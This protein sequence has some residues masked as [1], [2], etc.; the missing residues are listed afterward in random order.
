MSVHSVLAVDDGFKDRT[1]DEI[2]STGCAWISSEKNEGKGLALKRA[3]EAILNNGT[4]P[5]KDSYE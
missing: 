5:V 3:F 4:G 1:L 2:R